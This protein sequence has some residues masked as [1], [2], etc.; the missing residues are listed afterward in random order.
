MKRTF[1]FRAVAIQVLVGFFVACSSPAPDE[2]KAMIL[3][4]SKR[5]FS[6]L[7]ASLSVPDGF[8]IQEGA[9][10]VL[11]HD[12]TQEYIC[13]VALYPMQSVEQVVE[14]ISNQQMGMGLISNSWG[15]CGS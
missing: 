12:A 3:S 15:S 8:V 10:N 1:I 13:L 6:G 11:L 5:Y 2:G 14:N 7:Q 9:T 4:E